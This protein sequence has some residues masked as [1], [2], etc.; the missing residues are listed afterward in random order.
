MAHEIMK[1]SDLL[2]AQ[3]PGTGTYTYVII[4]SLVIYLLV[5]TVFKFPVAFIDEQQCCQCGPQKAFSAAE[6]GI[7]WCYCIIFKNTGTSFF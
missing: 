2:F 6:S 4:I 1:Y 5:F 7:G 3:V